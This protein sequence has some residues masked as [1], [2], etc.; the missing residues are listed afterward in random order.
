MTPEQLRTVGELRHLAVTGEARVLR[1]S[2]HI[3]L[4]E[5]ARV[6]GVSPSAL[7]RWENR[8]NLPRGE[9]ALKWAEALGVKPSAENGAALVYQ[10][11]ASA[12]NSEAAGYQPAAPIEQSAST[13]S[14]K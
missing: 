14:S 8:I 13:S 6:I 4:R 3:G 11:G 9:H 5:L 1:K 7:S 12:R 10:T 2:L